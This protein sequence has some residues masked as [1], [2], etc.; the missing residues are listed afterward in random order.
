MKKDNFGKNITLEFVLGFLGGLLG[1]YEGVFA[2][3]YPAYVVAYAYGAIIAS[4][5][6]FIGVI[7]LNKNAKL[8]GIILIV[9]SIGLL[10]TIPTKIGLSG[11]VLLAVAGLLKL[12]TVIQDYRKSSWSIKGTSSLIIFS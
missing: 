1:L 6:G 8:S 2:L 7:Y 5:V 12:E 4:I 9:A 3:L 11:S 10:L